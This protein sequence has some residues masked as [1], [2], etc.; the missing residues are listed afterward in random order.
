MGDMF[1]ICRVAGYTI[2]AV[3]GIE[4]H[5]NRAADVSH[6]NEDIDWNRSIKNYDL[7]V[8]EQGA[9]GYAVSIDY[10]AEV[11]KRISALE[12]PK[13]LR[14]D[15]LVMAQ[16]FISASPEFFNTND[17]GEFHNWK[18]DGLTETQKKYFED[19]YDFVCKK[20]GKEN[21]ISARIHLD[22]ETPHMHINFVPIVEQKIFEKSDEKKKNKRGDFILDKKKNPVF[23]LK[24]AVGED[25]KPKTR[26]T[27]CYSD[28]F[29]EKAQINRGRQGGQL[30][31]L[32]DEFFE[33]S[34]KC[35]YKNLK[36]GEIRGTGSKK[37]H[38]QVL[39]FK[40]NERA[41]EVEEL[42]TKLETVTDERDNLAADLAVMR[43]KAVELEKGN[44]DLENKITTNT[45]ILDAQTAQMEV[46]RAELEALAAKKKTISE[47]GESLTLAQLE[48]ISKSKMPI[49]GEMKDK[50]IALALASPRVKTKKALDAVTAEHDT[51]KRKY[52]S[53]VKQLKEKEN[54]I[55]LLCTKI[56]E[57][58]SFAEKIINEQPIYQKIA[59]DAIKAAKAK[60]LSS[61]A[62]DLEL[63]KQRMSRKEPQMVHETDP[64]PKQKD[65]SK[66]I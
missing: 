32:Q 36:R 10:R 24:Q 56:P 17:R 23:E 66:S 33:N 4:R 55:S 42:K 63:T 37:K 3:G 41:K 22:E 57:K 65:N 39:D 21:I 13:A 44:S 2:S 60:R 46:H 47:L 15:A 31:A 14:N 59:L 54:H 62:S 19:K 20:Y 40:R 1:G 61:R 16:F 27:V 25:G 26:Q 18:K 58:D 28:L 12:L 64:L 49:Y 5:D 34:Q 8:P 9:D 51:L 38:L 50:I 30:S 29:T 35:G 6:T 43:S 48:K 53:V 45:G 7:H 11:E 52:D